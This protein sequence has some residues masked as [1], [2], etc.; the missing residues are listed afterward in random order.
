M[1]N[2]DRPRYEARVCKEWPQNLVVA[3]GGRMYV[4]EEYRTVPPE[5]EHEMD[6]H[7]K[8]IKRRNGKLTEIPMLEYR[9]KGVKKA[10][11][12]EPKTQPKAQA[13]AAQKTPA[14]KGT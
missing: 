12:P 4:K 11:K 9:D 1:T 13:K 10:E 3:F 2:Q 5:F 14:K 6:A 7:K 8:A